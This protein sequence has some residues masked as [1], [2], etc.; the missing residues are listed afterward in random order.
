M[1]RCK[2]VGRSLLRFVTMHAFIF[3]NELL[4][5]RLHGIS[6][7]VMEQWF[8]DTELQVSCVAFVPAAHPRRCQCIYSYT[9]RSRRVQR[10]R[11]SGVVHVGM[12]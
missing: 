6:S 3:A 9:A 7:L 2:N 10:R 11:K 12:H 1:Q 8:D 5:Q 4:V